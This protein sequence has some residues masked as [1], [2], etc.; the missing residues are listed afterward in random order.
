M[1][2]GASDN[3]ASNDSDNQATMR[4]KLSL[5][6]IIS[7]WEKSMKERGVQPLGCQAYD[8][9]RLAKTSSLKAEPHALFHC[10]MAR[11]NPGEARWR[12]PCHRRFFRAS[13]PS[14]ISELR[15]HPF[16]PAPQ[17]AREIACPRTC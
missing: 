14:S 15:P 3:A 9:R 10:F 1:A 11:P 7:P 2:A 12:P 17:S 6:T 5:I 13:F 16:L 8:M 4:K